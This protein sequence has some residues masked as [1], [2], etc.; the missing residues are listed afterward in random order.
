MSVASPP[1]MLRMREI[2]GTLEFPGAADNPIIL[3]WGGMIARQFPVLHDYCLNYT[4]DEIAWCGYCMGLCTATCDV[5][6]M[7]PYNPADDTHSFM[8]AQAWKDLPGEDITMKPRRGGICVLARHVTMF[9]RIENGRYICIGGNQ[10]DAVKESA[11]SP[12]AIEKMIW[13]AN[14][15]TIY[16]PDEQQFSTARTN[17]WLQK[18]LNVLDARLTKRLEED[19]D[20]GEQTYR[21][22]REFQAG[23]RLPV[24]GLAG[25]R[26][27]AAI[28]AELA[29]RKISV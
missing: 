3:S 9:D 16:L 28:D 14:Q 17:L 6:I 18:S 2:E 21:I 23:F 29:F 27:I 15:P 20:Y 4:H 1:W 11:F 7:P 25:A 24:T 13:P 8:W 26:D 5:H 22:M 10:S 12:G 19:G